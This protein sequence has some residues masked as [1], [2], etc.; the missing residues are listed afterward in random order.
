MGGKTLKA[1]L[2]HRPGASKGDDSVAGDCRNEVSKSCRQTFTGKLYRNQLWDGSQVLQCSAVPWQHLPDSHHRKKACF[3]DSPCPGALPHVLHSPWR[4]VEPQHS[5]RCFPL[6]MTASMALCIKAHLSFYCLHPPCDTLPGMD[7]LDPPLACPLQLCVS[8]IC[9]AFPLLPAQCTNCL[10]VCPLSSGCSPISWC[11]LKSFF[12]L[13]SQMGGY[14][15]WNWR[16]Q[17]QPGLLPP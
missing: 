17:V 11:T 8:L 9:A 3:S 1:G 5:Q 6:V 13:V 15:Q 14:K 16:Y 7:P 10:G 12:R 4:G 2:K